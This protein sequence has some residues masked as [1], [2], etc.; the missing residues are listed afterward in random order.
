MEKYV[1]KRNGEYKP[2]EPFKIK[3]AIEKSFLSVSIAIDES[4]FENII[5]DLQ[6]KE[7]W[8]VEE[9]QDLIEKNLFEKQNLISTNKINIETKYLYHGKIR[10]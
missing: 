9:I 1:I 2:F 10:D 4:V 3:D 5:T 6:A 8:A 7:T